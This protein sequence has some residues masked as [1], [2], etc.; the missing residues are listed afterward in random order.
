[1]NLN[2]VIAESVTTNARR[3]PSVYLHEVHGLPETRTH[4][5]WTRLAKMALRAWRQGA[6]SISGRAACVDLSYF[7]TAARYLKSRGN[8]FRWLC[9]HMKYPTDL[10]R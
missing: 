7:T 9:E 3:K 4:G 8:E 10:M 5:D 2:A 6:D 1:M